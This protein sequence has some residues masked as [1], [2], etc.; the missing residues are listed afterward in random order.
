MECSRL[1]PEY[2]VGMEHIKR[3]RFYTYT[4][5]LTRYHSFLNSGSAGSDESPT[6]LTVFALSLPAVFTN[7]LY[8]LFAR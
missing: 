7:G 1:N 6:L 8:P 2:F 5:L 4:V 3:T